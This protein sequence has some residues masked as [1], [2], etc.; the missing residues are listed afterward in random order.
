MKAY[1]K[2]FGKL[3]NHIELPKPIP[4]DEIDLPKLIP[5]DDI[6]DEEEII[7]KVNEIDM[8]KLID[9]KDDDKEI[10]N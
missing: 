3:V 8:P 5:C 10:N 6:D 9:R 1:L 4:C 7:N 2:K